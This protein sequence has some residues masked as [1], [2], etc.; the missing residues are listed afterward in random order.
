MYWGRLTEMITGPELQYVYLRRLLHNFGIRF[1]REKSER[2]MKDNK[3]FKDVLRRVQQLKRESSVR[4][5]IWNVPTKEPP[6]T[7]LGSYKNSPRG[8]NESPSPGGKDMPSYLRASPL[9]DSSPL[10]LRDYQQ[11]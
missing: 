9:R 5:A 4:K 6:K 2:M 3:A 1:D 8:K 11:K 7:V 10:P